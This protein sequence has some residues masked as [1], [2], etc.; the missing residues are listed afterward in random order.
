[1]TDYADLRDLSRFGSRIALIAGD[2]RELTYAELAQA[3]EDTARALGPD[4]RLLL[5]E[6]KND[7]RTVVSLLAALQTGHPVILT[8][9]G[10]TGAAIA[11]TY[12]PSAII[13]AGSDDDLP[14]IAEHTGAPPVA[15]H[16]ELA[17]MLSTSGSTGSPK[18]VRLSLASLQANAV[19]IATYLELGAG[20][21]AI[22]SLPLH[23]SYGLSVITSHLVAGGSIVLTETSVADAAFRS[24]CE[25]HEVTGV[26]G[27][28]Y[29]YEL[30]EQSGFLER[31]P[32]SI[33]TLT[34]AGGRLGPD[35]VAAV[36][37]RARAQGA[38]LF[39]MYG[40]TEATARMAYLT[41]EL[42][43]DNPDAIGHAIPGGEFRLA[44]ADGRPIGRAGEAGELV[45]HGP[46]V[47]LGYAQ[48]PEDL[49]RGREI[50]ELHTG[51]IATRDEAGLYR[52]VGRM[53]R[54]VKLFGLRIGLDDVEA[55]YR[56]R[57]IEAVAA[58]D[59]RMLA[60]V[61][62]ADHDAGAERAW[63]ASR[64]KL[65]E[66][67]IH[68]ATGEIPR[69]PTGKPDYGTIM[70][71][72]S[73]RADQ[74]EPQDNRTVR[75]LFADIFP[76]RS[77]SGDDTFVSL[78]GD[79][80]TYVQASI[81]LE[82]ILRQLPLE[83]QDKTIDE[84]SALPRAGQGT[85][86]WWTPRT[87]GSDILVRAAAIL[88]VVINHASDTWLVGGGANVLL[89]L[90][91][92][93]FLRYQGAHLTGLDRL[94][95]LRN[96][97]LRI[98]LPYYALLIAYSVGTGQYDWP[99]FFLVSN[100]TGRFGNLM[101]PY[102]FLELVAQCL[103]ILTV[104][105]CLK[106]VRTLAARSPWT[107]G[108]GFFAVASAVGLVSQIAFPRPDLA[109]RLPEFLF[110]FIAFGWCVGLAKDRAQ[111]TVLSVLAIAMA[112]A[113]ATISQGQSGAYLKMPQQI[114]WFVGS[115]L[116]LLWLPRLALPGIARRVVTEIAGAV[117]QIYLAHNIVVHMF[118]FV[119]HY[120]NL[121]VILLLSVLAGVALR[122]AQAFTASLYS[123]YVPLVLPSRSAVAIDT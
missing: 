96:Y 10:G 94:V 21:R 17:L 113:I 111:K 87:F 109:F 30:M 121:A 99:A 119:W 28:P 37:D 27:V 104:L 105:F 56:K 47:M 9:S 53:S 34:Q 54:F 71:A 91:G 73:E 65:P 112:V 38:R 45:Y 68:I 2:G 51:D 90:F 49:A 100:F 41:P 106:P 15:L 123:R 20:S 26:A 59:D 67:A 61:L 11:S 114:V 78:G 29:S 86:S 22:T 57:G 35:K 98:I 18:L 40:Q 7:V 115:A 60:M 117:F 58:G 83:W 97:L 93:N 8:G 120:D 75:E 74:S 107:F 70:A 33:D 36:A 122:Y 66:T 89:V 52:I 14:P 25:R 81:G 85:R 101:E 48:G 108:L 116:I 63:L 3:V 19:S 23:Y 5:L 13:R 118:L 110:W 12:H 84:L 79:S 24:L 95:P 39:V 1:M 4:R 69:L 62:P 43:P 46:N 32:P 6:A 64:L 44:D 77:L 55:L 82:E 16:D 42:A 72:A 102:W 103:V 31:L 76:G 88:A 50:E 92:L 80:L